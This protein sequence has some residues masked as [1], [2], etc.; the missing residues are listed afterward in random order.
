MFVCVPST[1]RY[2]RAVFILQCFNKGLGLLRWLAGKESCRQIQV[3]WVGSW[4]GK[5][6]WRRKG[7]PILVFLPG[8]CQRQ[9]S[10]AGYSPWGQRV[11]YDLATKPQQQ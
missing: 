8:K 6:T 11:R 7:Q 3:T 4:V 10:L 2:L 9:K 5:I 1:D